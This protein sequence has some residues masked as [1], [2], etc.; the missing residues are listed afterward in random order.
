MKI[1]P[2][3]EVTLSREPLRA[4]QQVT[5]ELYIYWND[6]CGSNFEANMAEIEARLVIGSPEMCVVL[7]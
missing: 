5:S 4:Q 6:N 3:C 7:N 2:R 1:W